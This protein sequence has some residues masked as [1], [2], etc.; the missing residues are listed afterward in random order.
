HTSPQR[1]DAPMTVFSTFG[2]SRAL[3]APVVRLFRTALGRDPGPAELAAFVRRLRE[4]AATEELAR[5][6]A[7]SDEFPRLHGPDA[8]PDEAFVE[9]IAS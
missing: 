1:A 4:G 2:E 5:D 8:P 6:L 7:A 3:G 9:R